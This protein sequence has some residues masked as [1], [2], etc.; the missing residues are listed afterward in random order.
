MIPFPV[1]YVEPSIPGTLDFIGFSEG[2][3]DIE[4]WKKV[5]PKTD[6]SKIDWKEV[7][8]QA[9]SGGHSL[10]G[11]TDGISA[12]DKVGLNSKNMA[13]RLSHKEKQ[14]NRGEVLCCQIV[15]YRTDLC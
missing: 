2:S 13:F 6:L 3:T 12:Y 14:G 11:K 15:P 1:C 8:E 5:M 10:Y 4:D 9:F 7:T